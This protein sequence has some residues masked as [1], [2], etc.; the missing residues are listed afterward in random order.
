MIWT[1]WKCPST[2]IKTA[3]PA[4]GAAAVA[5]VAAAV[6]VADTAAAS[7]PPFTATYKG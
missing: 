1:N 5:S 3:T 4:G 7:P 2:K 6:A